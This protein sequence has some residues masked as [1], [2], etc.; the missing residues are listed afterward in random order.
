MIFENK[1]IQYFMDLHRM[2][3]SILKQFLA[4][5]TF[6]FINKIKVLSST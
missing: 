3:T 2:F 5:K 6:L 4:N 1:T